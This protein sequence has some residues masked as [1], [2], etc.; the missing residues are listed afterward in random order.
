MEDDK[1]PLDVAVGRMQ[2]EFCP[3]QSEFPSFERQERDYQRL[4]DLSAD[5]TSGDT[6]VIVKF[7][8]GDFVDCRGRKVAISSLPS[9]LP[10]ACL[11]KLTYLA[12][13]HS[14]VQKSS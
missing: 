7:P 13:P 14:G 12:Y 2:Q 1:S 4:F 10:L 8:N 6:L 3:K 11:N 9:S 5:N